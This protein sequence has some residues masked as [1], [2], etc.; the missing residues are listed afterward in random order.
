MSDKSPTKSEILGV[1]EAQSETIESISQRI[2]KIE[3]LIE[4]QDSKNQNVIVG[5]LIASVLIVVTVAIETLHSNN[6]DNK[7]FD[8]YMEDRNQDNIN[9]LN[10]FNELQKQIELLRAKNPYLK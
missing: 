5:V 10:S 4:K 1:V 6:S 8:K 9:F 7:R 2:V 3:G